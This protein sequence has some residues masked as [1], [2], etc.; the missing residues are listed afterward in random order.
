MDTSNL[1]IVTQRVY[2]WQPS[3]GSYPVLVDRL[4]PRGIK[5]ERLADVS[6][7]KD[8][9]PSAELRKKYHAGTLDFAQFSAEYEA[10]LDASEAPARLLH[11][12]A[13][14]HASQLVLLFAA[15]D[16]AHAHVDVLADHLRR[17]R[18]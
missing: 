3:T 6:W 1:D 4:W 8:V 2:D 10:E 16:T 9:A 11:S 12:A 5:K 17:L 13:D 7:D 15:K 14:A 18:Q